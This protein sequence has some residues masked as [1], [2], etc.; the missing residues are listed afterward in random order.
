MIWALCQETKKL[1]CKCSHSWAE[2]KE[3]P[4]DLKE[5][6][7]QVQNDNG[8]STKQISVYESCL[9]EDRELPKEKESVISNEPSIN[10][11]SIEGVT[12]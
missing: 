5:K 3:E 7:N 10:Y 4:K 2:R 12:S 9:Q 8:S 11:Y 1:K 6:E